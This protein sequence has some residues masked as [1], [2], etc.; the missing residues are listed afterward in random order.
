MK[1]DCFQYI[2][3]GILLLIMSY[4]FIS[5]DIKILEGLISNDDLACSNYIT[6][7]AQL[8]SY[9][10]SL[11]ASINE[12]NLA[13]NKTNYTSIER[14]MNDISSN[15]NMNLTNK[16]NYICELFYIVASIHSKCSNKCFTHGNIYFNN[17]TKSKQFDNTYLSPENPSMGISSRTDT[18][19]TMLSKNIRFYRSLLMGS[20]SRIINFINVVLNPSIINPLNDISNN[21]NGMKITNNTI[22]TNIETISTN[23]SNIQNTQSS[24]GFTCMYNSVSDTDSSVCIVSDYMNKTKSVVTGDN[25]P[26]N[27]IVSAMLD[28]DLNIFGESDTINCNDCNTYIKDPSKSDSTLKVKLNNIIDQSRILDTSLNDIINSLDVLASD[29]QPYVTKCIELFQ[30]FKQI[31]Q[32]TYNGNIL[33]PAELATLVDVTTPLE[34][35]IW[36]QKSLANNTNTY[37]ALRFTNTQA[38]NNNLNTFLSQILVNFNKF[39]NEISKVEEL[40]EKFKC[41]LEE[42]IEKSGKYLENLNSAYGNISKSWIKGESNTKFNIINQFVNDLFVPEIFTM[43]YFDSNDTNVFKNFDP[44]KIIQTASTK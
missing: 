10:V 8:P 5:I 29:I 30:N 22:V 25:T 11:D 3:L 16:T 13:D 40:C 14:M 38:L 9:L 36:N 31:F 6:S 32:C 33:T 1:K 27:S 44:Q 20:H 41:Y 4:I 17:T 28:T 19:F 35:K 12:F 34:L 37:N 26:Y 39:Y 2:I 24:E 7:D 15:T 18:F 21:L 42:N 23:L 43:Q